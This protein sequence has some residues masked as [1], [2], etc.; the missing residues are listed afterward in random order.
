VWPRPTPASYYGRYYR[1][2]S[3]NRMLLVKVFA[4]LMFFIV[5]WTSFFA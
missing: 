3:S 4:T 1:S 2:M 5:V